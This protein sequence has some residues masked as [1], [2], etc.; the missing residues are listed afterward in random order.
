MIWRWLRRWWS[1]EDDL[2][3]D[4]RLRALRQLGIR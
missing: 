3:E 1:G 2:L 4:S